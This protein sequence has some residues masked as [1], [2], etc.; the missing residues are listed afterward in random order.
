[1]GIVVFQHSNSDIAK[2][3]VPD[4]LVHVVPLVEK[5][6][7]RPFHE[8]TII[9]CQSSIKDGS[10]KCKQRK[11]QWHLAVEMV[12]ARDRKVSFD[13]TELEIIVDIISNLTLN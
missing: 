9:C 7:L 10:D 4:P 8:Q 3:R 11:R 13:D 2:L 1:M 12:E 5:N 6:S